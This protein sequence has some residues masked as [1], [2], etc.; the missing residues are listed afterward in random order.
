MKF[1]PNV[2]VETKT[3]TVVVDP[4]LRPGAHRFRLVVE[5]KRGLQSKPAEVVVTVLRG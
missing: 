5:N 3:P 4:G 2:P 1:V